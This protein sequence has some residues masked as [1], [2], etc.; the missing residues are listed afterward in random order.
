MDTRDKKKTRKTPIIG[1]VLIVIL[2]FIG[3]GL[4]KCGFLYTVGGEKELVV[5]LPIIELNISDNNYIGFNN[6]QI[7]KITRDGITAY[8]LKGQQL[9]S[10]ALSLE[11]YVVKQRE[12]YIAVGEKDGKSITIFS[13]KG[14]QGEIQS[15][16]AI[17]YFSINKKGGVA[18]IEDGGESYTVSAYD[19]KGRFLAGRVTYCKESGYP[20]VTELS[21]ENNLLLVSYVNM[22][23]PVLTSELVAI[24]LDSYD[25][26]VI[27]NVTYGLEQK[28]NLI[29]EIEFLKD[30]EWISIGDKSMTTYDL[31]GNPITTISDMNCVFTPYSV[32]TSPYGKGY[33]PIVTTDS[34]NKN[35]I[36][37]S[38][39]LIYMDNTGEEVF[40]VEV[41]EPITYYYADDKGVIIG[42]KDS[43]KG[44]NKLGVLLFS[45][46]ATSDINKVFY[47][48]DTKT[49]IAVARNKVF[50]LKPKKEVNE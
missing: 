26:E 29:Y 23:K 47:L 39:K 3:Y 31:E 37:R 2:G 50:L 40:K 36:H 46:Q 19:S 49:G 25:E 14:K 21:P 48:P 16:H 13:D 30:N 42:T 34:M 41:D 1:V 15:T 5:N 12:P 17:R 7:I 35:T 45:Y 27:D 11:N 32:S 9:W 22:N 38:D 24:K 18:T 44:Y 20:I 43:Y 8:D 28:D 4:F 6:K 10:D 33:L